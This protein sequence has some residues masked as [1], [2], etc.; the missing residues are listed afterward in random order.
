MRLQEEGSW[1]EAED[2]GLG[3]GETTLPHIGGG[4]AETNEVT[5]G[6]KVSGG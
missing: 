2:L 6:R 4:G 3:R 5:G 1:A